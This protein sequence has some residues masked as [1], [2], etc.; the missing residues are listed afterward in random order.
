MAEQRKVADRLWAYSDAV[1]AVIV[2]VMVLQLR[3]PTSH[4]FSSLLGLWP[5]LTSYVASYVFIAIIWINYHYLS[6]FVETPSLGL[7][8]INFLHLLFVSLIPFTTAWMARTRLASDPVIVY[9]ALFVCAASV[10]NVLEYH[11]FKQTSLISRTSRQTARRRSLLALLLFG[12]AI[13]P[14]RRSSHGLGSLWSARRSCSTSSQTSAPAALLP[15]TEHQ[16]LERVR[17]AEP[18]YRL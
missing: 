1:F 2:T 17:A 6:R 7:V 14:P 15:R 4:H 16:V 11:V 3:T 18:L 13:P 12:L 5:T 9:T 10:F 8:W